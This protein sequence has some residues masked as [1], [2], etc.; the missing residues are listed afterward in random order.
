MIPSPRG[1]PVSAAQWLILSR[2]A[3]L[4]A[5][6]AAVATALNNAAAAAQVAQDTS[7]L[8]LL[9][10][11]NDS[12]KFAA[13]I[14]VRQ[15]TNGDDTAAAQAALEACRV[16][17]GGEVVIP[18][19][20]KVWRFRKLT[21]S[22]NT[23]FRCAPGV[24][25]KRKGKSYGFTNLV[26]GVNPLKDNADPYSGHGNIKILG[27]VWDGNIL[28]E[29]YLPAGFN[30]FYFVGARGIVIED[31]TVRD[32]VTNHCV[33]LDGVTGVEIRRC[34][35]LGYKDGTADASRGYVE[36]IQCSQNTDASSPAYYPM[37]GTPSS[38]ITVENNTFGAS[39][40]P[41]TR[42]YP[43]GFGTHYSSNDPLTNTITIRNNKF[44]GQTFA[45][46]VGYT[47]N[48]VKVTG[49]TF[50]GCVIGVKANNF[51]NGK[52][53]N[54]TKNAW[55]KGGPTRK[56]TVG[57]SVTDNDFI[58]TVATDVSILGTTRD[59]KGYWAA[60]AG[61]TIANNRMKATTTKKRTGNNIR[62]LLCKNGIVANNQCSNSAH[63]IRVE[64]CVNID[65]H[66]NKVT[67]AG[68]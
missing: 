65:V 4:A 48:N 34:R 27:G 2:R 20:G 6:L 32:M 54:K 15:S 68:A 7:Q 14:V 67:N 26:P 40:T 62:L 58:N 18:Y 42:A 3:C 56:E 8:K 46:V 60:C 41:G 64:S 9:T 11:A 25:I 39:G 19:T 63:G 36:A 59:A 35:F 33:D 37:L 1:T 23:T 44:N 49:N 51:T 38:R 29:P 43:A 17:G 28:S 47:Y 45:A 61:I 24:V 13:A 12:K 22:R 31:V 50:T 57:F 21:I 53:W 10:K 52:T 30:L 55:I 16:A 66:G 5:A